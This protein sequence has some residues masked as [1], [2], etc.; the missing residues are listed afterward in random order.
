MTPCLAHGI[1]RK[2]RCRK[3]PDAGGICSHR[4]RRGRCRVCNIT[5]SLADNV[6]SRVRSALKGGKSKKSIEYLGC[7]INEFK[8][9]I[10]K[11]FT[12]DMDWSNH[13]TMWHVDHIICIQ[14]KGIDRKAPT[15][16]QVIE[17]L[18]FTNCQPMLASENMSKGSRYC[19]KFNPDF[20][21]KNKK[22]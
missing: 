9:H 3:C 11:Q 17:R 16:D 12:G 4:V 18:H 21:S 5:G 10:E 6:S 15:Y 22:V 1:T 20:S 8:E 14:Y 2:S 19:G 13:G 7:S